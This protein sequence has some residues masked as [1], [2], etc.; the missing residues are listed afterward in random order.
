VEAF[1]TPRAR[2]GNEIL[3]HKTSKSVEQIRG[4][5]NLREWDMIVA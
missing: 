1:Y 4:Y 3:P 2:E 5:S